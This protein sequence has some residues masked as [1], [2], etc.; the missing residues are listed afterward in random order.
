M[1]G[2]KDSGRKCTWAY[3]MPPSDIHSTHHCILPVNEKLC[4]CIILRSIQTMLYI[5]E[6]LDLG[7]MFNYLPQPTFTAKESM[8][9]QHQL[10]YAMNVACDLV[11]VISSTLKHS[12]LPSQ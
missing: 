6:F 11:T 2:G 1:S 8:K 7:E 12:S 9:C 5:Y 3:T 4:G 10:R